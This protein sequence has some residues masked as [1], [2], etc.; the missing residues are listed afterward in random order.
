V[1][2]GLTTG[3]TTQGP[4]QAKAFIVSLH[5]LAGIRREETMLLPVTI[6]GVRLIAL[7]DSGSMHNFLSVATMRRLGLQLSG[8]EQLSVTIANGDRL[9]CQGM[10]RQVPILIGD[11]HFSV[12][13][14]GI[15][16]GFFNFNLDVDVLRTLGPILWDFDARTLIFWRLGRRIR[17]E[18]VGGAAP[19]APQLQLAAVAL[20]GEHPLL[21]ALLQ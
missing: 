3:A 8:A 13:C 9:A 17:W 5:A 20:D 12:N 21:D 10:A 14:I 7:L 15:D 16:L 4:V 1:V 19:M 2:C 18:G 6:N 11:E